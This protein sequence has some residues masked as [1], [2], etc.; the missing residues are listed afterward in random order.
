MSDP[1][2][3]AANAIS[4]SSPN[5]RLFAQQAALRIVAV[6]AA[7]ARLQP[8]PPPPAT[9][10]LGNGFI[11]DLQ[12]TRYAQMTD[13]ERAKYGAITV[14]YGDYAN[15]A[16]FG[17]AHPSVH[18]LGYQTSVEVGT[19]TWYGAVLYSEAH[20]NGWILRD[21]AGNELRIGTLYAGDIG[22]IAYQ[23]AW[24][25]YVRQR[26][27]DTGLHAKFLDNVTGY[28]WFGTAINPRTGKVYTV[29]EWQADYLAFLA[30]QQ[31]AL[32][33]IYRVAN[34]Y[35]VAERLAWTQAV[36]P[37]V[38]GVMVEYYDDSAAHRALLATIVAAGKDPYAL[39]DQSHGQPGPDSPAGIALAHGFAAATVERK[40]GG[41][42]FVGVN[43]WRDGAGSWTAAIGA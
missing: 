10:H 26:A 29:A 16:S 4:V 39:V 19:N 37:Y 3:N 41:F 28:P 17:N 42:G 31:A 11:A 22:N 7:V 38:D 21:A 9:T 27:T 23:R 15:V 20:A 14:G 25:D 6:E 43:V 35:A 1:L 36:L 30:Y 32:P 2:I 18:G 8:A 24:C 33:G 34:V 13:T 40:G 5:V 12:G